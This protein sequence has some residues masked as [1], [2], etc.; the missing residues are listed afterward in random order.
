[1]QWHN[2]LESSCTN[3]EPPVPPSFLW[4]HVRPEHMA[5]AS[6]LM[7][8]A[9]LDRLLPSIPPRP[10]HREYARLCFAA[11]CS[12]VAHAYWRVDSKL[13]PPQGECEH[14]ETNLKRE[15]TKE[16]LYLTSVVR[17]SLHFVF[18]KTSCT[19]YANPFNW[20]FVDVNSRGILASVMEPKK[21]WLCIPL[22][23]TTCYLEGSREFF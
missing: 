5:S 10:F 20:S 14:G 21:L 4:G 17:L 7:S 9:A 18:A 22:L 15:K 19:Y 2:Y 1:M 13:Q 23:Q 16:R 12:S 3:T 8:A 11:H 6:P